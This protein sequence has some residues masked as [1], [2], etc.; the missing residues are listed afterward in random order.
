MSESDRQLFQQ[1]QVPASSVPSFANA[2]NSFSLSS[3]PVTYSN[4]LM[5]SSPL[6]NS[7]RSNHNV[8]IAS[9][10]ATTIQVPPTLTT[11]TNLESIACA[12]ASPESGLDIHDRM[13]LKIRI[14]NAFI[15]SDVVNWLF[16]C[17]QGFRDRKDAKKF[18]SKL[19]KQGFIQHTIDL[20]N[21]FSEK[22]YY[23][24]SD[25]V[26]HKASEFNSLSQYA[27]N[28]SLA[29]I[30][31][32]FSSAL[33]IGNDNFQQSN[34]IDRT[35]FNSVTNQHFAMTPNEFAG[36]V[37]PAQVA[38]NALN[39]PRPG[40]LPGFMRY[41][42]ENSEIQNYGLFGPQISSDAIANTGHINDGTGS[43]HSG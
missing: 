21:S 10:P 11:E 38:M 12:M 14:P 37:N 19:L 39:Q 30:E 8:T 13:W 24:F 15:G 17:V 43:N 29:G 16:S 7:I 3:A 18:A 41:W 35:N 40:Y 2:S 34:S 6:R 28:Q 32:G 42:D 26:I 4:S 33:R 23:V 1:P 5:P 9:N 36:Q 31:E 22:C 25:L 27:T 20:K